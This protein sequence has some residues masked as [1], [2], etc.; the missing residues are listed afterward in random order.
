MAK[1]SAARARER[2]NRNAPAVNS[3]ARSAGSYAH[4]SDCI[5]RTLRCVLYTRVLA[6]TSMLSRGTGITC[7]C[8][9]ARSV[10]CRA[11]LRQHYTHPASTIPR[12]ALTH[13]S[14]SLTHCPSLCCRPGNLGL[15][16]VAQ[17]SSILPVPSLATEACYLQSLTESWNTGAELMGL[18]A[19][20]DVSWN[21]SGVSAPTDGAQLLSEIALLNVSASLDG[22]HVPRC[23][24][25]STHPPPLSPFI[26]HPFKWTFWNAIR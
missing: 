12:T 22:G 4:R 24:L 17:V 23:A 9:F 19:L 1:C 20:A 25:H 13:N 21:M 2:V 8:P 7:K 10:L 5:D 15:N 11:A 18:D 3:L 14:G 16:Y 6:D 26:P